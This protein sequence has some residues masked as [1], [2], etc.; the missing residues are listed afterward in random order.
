MA[1]CRNCGSEVSDEAVVCPHCGVQVKELAKT[2]S[3]AHIVDSGGFGWGLLGF[4]IPVVGLVLYLVW[5]YDRP[6]TSKALGI[7]A[8]VGFISSIIIYVVYFIFFFDYLYLY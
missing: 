6:L 7:G 3:G 2:K 8:L 4:C 1:Y 5:R